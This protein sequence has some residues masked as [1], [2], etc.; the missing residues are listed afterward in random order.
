MKNSIGEQV[1]LLKTYIMKYFKES[2][3]KH[4]LITGSKK[5]GKTTILK[6]ILKYESSFGGI[7]T[8]VIRDNKVPPKFVILEDIND[9]NEKG[10]IAVRN[11]TSTALI[12]NI[13][14][15]EII[16]TSILS[17]YIDS[18]VEL[19]VIDEIG[20]LERDAINYQ[21]KVFEILDK[22]KTILIL[23]KELNPFI[24]KIINRQ[25]VYLVDIDNMKNLLTYKEWLIDK[26]GV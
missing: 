8:Y 3:K 11:E 23:R 4:L 1:K 2:N 12:P 24:E 9:S 19:I 16:G 20:F 6:E 7:V 15:F 14:T 21:D 10:I 13:N 5:S 18:N 17:K 26:R 22:K 25:D